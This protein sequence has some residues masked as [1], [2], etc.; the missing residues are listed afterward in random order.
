MTRFLS[1]ACLVTLLAAPCWAEDPPV[2]LLKWGSQG[3]GPGQFGY[4]VGIAAGPNDDIYITDGSLNRVQRFTSN[5]SFIC[6][7]G[8]SG[9]GDGQF[10]GCNGVAVGPDN[11]VYV[12]D[13]FNRR[14]EVFDGN[15]TYTRQWTIPG[16]LGTGYIATDPVLGR[17]Y[18]AASRY[19]LMF[20][21]TGTYLGSWDYLG[22]DPA[23]SFPFAV[24][25]SG[26]LYFPDQARAS[27]R[28]FSSNGVFLRSWGTFGQGP[29][30]L[31]NPYAL[32]I[33]TRENVY[34]VD[35]N[36]R[37]QEFTSDGQFLTT[38]GSPGSGD[39]QFLGIQDLC[40]DS[41]GDVYVLE[42]VNYRVQKFG[43]APT[44]TLRRTWGSLKRAYR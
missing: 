7:V 38:W 8:T 20:D 42:W 41:H 36:R 22:Y 35:S 23:G 34:V 3:S 17:V 16:S 15:C 31:D 13:F 44:P 14:F 1:A 12:G 21:T 10:N 2:F 11:L 26:S 28:V 32:A 40:V 25:P 6:D 9:T 43:P 5:G 24:G 29:G 37:V 18:T 33:D 19:L 27:V 4:P 30:Q 39:G